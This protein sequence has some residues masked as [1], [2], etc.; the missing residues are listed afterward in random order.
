MTNYKG[1]LA[2][3]PVNTAHTIATHYRSALGTQPVNTTG[4]ASRLESEKWKCKVENGSWKME[5]GNAKWHGTHRP[6]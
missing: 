5:I 2:T 3:W 1:R 6:R 4:S